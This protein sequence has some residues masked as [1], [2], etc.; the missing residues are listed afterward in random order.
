MAIY[1][2]QCEKCFVVERVEGSSNKPPAAYNGCS[3]AWKQ[4]G[5][6]SGKGGYICKKCGR[7]IDTTST[8]KSAKCPGGPGGKYGPHIWQKL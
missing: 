7:Q 8:P 2:W 3:H 6:R 5:Q 4:L 1:Y